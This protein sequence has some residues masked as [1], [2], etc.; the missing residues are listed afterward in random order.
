[1]RGGFIRK[2]V[3]TLTLGE[4]LKKAR[5]KRRIS[6]MDVSRGTGIQVTYLER[7][8]EG[9]YD[10]LPA[11]VYVRGFLRRYAEYVGLREELLLRQYER[12][13]GTHR[14]LSS[15]GESTDT[16][17]SGA[18]RTLPS[19]TITPQRLMAMVIIVSVFGGLG[20]L[21]SE[22]R[23]FVSEPLLV[24][25][26]PIEQSI[27]LQKSQVIVKGY[28]D[29]NARVYINDQEVLLGEDGGFQEHIQLSQGSNQITVRA[30]NRFDKESVKTISAH[31]ETRQAT[32]ESTDDKK[33]FTTVKFRIV[34]DSTWVLVSVDGEQRVSRIFEVGEV[35]EFMPQ[36]SC[37]ISTGNGE[38]IYVTIDDEPESVLFVE[39]GIVREATLN[40]E[41]KQFLF[42]VQEEGG[43]KQ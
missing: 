32:S 39:G 9:R 21:Y 8:E 24:I 12:E 42:D 35:I 15:E 17:L 23:Q 31:V 1:M 37:S 6:L 7:I 34:G 30:I 40:F 41:K 16:F 4:R 14:H 38:N 28:V 33:S 43:D 19:I 13:S 25:D 26:E 2:K 5:D 20:Y 29:T 11:D 18:F 22:Y 10:T 27:T 36:K 3:G